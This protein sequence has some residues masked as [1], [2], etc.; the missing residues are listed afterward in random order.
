LVKPF[1]LEQG[2]NPINNTVN[3]ARYSTVGDNRAGD[4]ENLSSKT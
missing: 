4:C 1:S 3:N 2:C